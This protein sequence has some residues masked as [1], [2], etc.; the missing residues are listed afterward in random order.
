MTFMARAARD[1]SRILPF[2]DLKSEKIAAPQGLDKGLE[3]MGAPFL[4]R[5]A[6]KSR[7]R[8]LNAGVS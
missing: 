6:S 7:A 1:F 5:G 4:K 3:Q 2:C 8:F